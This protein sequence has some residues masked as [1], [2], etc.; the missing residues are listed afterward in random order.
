M[1]YGTYNKRYA[2]RIVEDGTVIDTFDTFVEAMATIRGYEAQDVA[3][4]YRLK[5]ENN[6]GWRDYEIYDTYERAILDRFLDAK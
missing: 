4:G 5:K 1:K 2:V 6:L 3:V